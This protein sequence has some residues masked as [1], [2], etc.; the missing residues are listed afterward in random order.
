MN[1][2]FGCRAALNMRLLVLGT[3]LLKWFKDRGLM[4]PYNKHLLLKG[5]ITIMENKYFGMARA[6]VLYCSAIVVVILLISVIARTFLWQP[7]NSPSGSQMPTLLVGDYFFVSKY[8][9]GYSRFSL[10]FNSLLFEG[11]LFGREPNRGDIAVFRLPSNTNLAYV[12]RVVGLPGDEI[13]VRGG[14]LFINGNA[15]PRQ[16]V[17]DFIE[18]D[19]FGARKI[20]QY[21]ETL[22]NQVTYRVLDARPN[23]RWDNVGPYKV[24]ADH[25][26][27]LGDNRD[28]SH[29]SRGKIGMV[30]FENLIGR[31]EII[32][33]STAH[34]GSSR[35]G[36]TLT[37]VQ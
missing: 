16:R 28:N 32:F 24:P 19:K 23:S 34:D 14:Q 9:Y 35:S 3:M 30:P 37:S 33:M 25:Y 36:R 13:E 6:V 8:A 5:N 7:F 1:T 29:D 15:V 27:F 21:E 10:P 31:A 12:K 17:E 11:R 2:F 26:F 20:P 4:V 18:K 22:P